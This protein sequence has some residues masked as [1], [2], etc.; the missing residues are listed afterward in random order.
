MRPGPAENTAVLNYISAIDA[1]KNSQ[2]LKKKKLQQSQQPPMYT[3]VIHNDDFT[4]MQFVIEMLMTVFNLSTDKAELITYR[5]HTAHRA[6]IGQYS[7][8]VAETKAAECNRLARQNE[9]P[10]LTDVEQV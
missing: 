4:P 1:M 3:V 6:K 7:R 8:E 9:H 10:L 2:V 5:I